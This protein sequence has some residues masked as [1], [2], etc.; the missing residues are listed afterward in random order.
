VSARLL[1]RRGST[2][3]NRWPGTYSQGNEDLLLRRFFAGRRGGIF[4]D[5]GA[6]HWRDGSNTYGF[7]RHLG[8]SGIAVDGLAEL[9]DGYRSNRPGTVFLNYV[10]TDRS[11]TSATFYLAGCL[12]ST[13]KA[14]LASFPNVDAERAPV[15]RVPAITLTDLLDEHG[16]TRVDLLSMDVEQGEPEA[17]TGFEI[18]RFRPGLVCVEAGTDEVREWLPPYFAGAGY[19][20]IDEYLEH[21]IGN[22]YFRPRRSWRRRGRRLGTRAPHE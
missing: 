9:G 4:V 22:W 1:R 21:D 6:G 7:E 13:R 12:S 2:D 15:V 19:E 11:E 3:E 5:V 17:L 14:H 20:R 16:V 10:V 18:S 8:W